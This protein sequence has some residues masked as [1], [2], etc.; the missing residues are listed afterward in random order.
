MVVEFNRGLVIGD[1]HADL[2]SLSYIL[3]RIKDGAIFLGDYA[4][5]G[6]EP[7]ESY[8]QILKKFNENQN[9]ILLR[10]NHESDAV[11]PHELPSQIKEY[12]GS[13]EVH[14]RLNKLWEKLPV[15]AI[16]KEKYWFI[17]AG[18]PTKGRED[19][20]EFKKEDFL[21]PSDEMVIEMLWNDPW[22]K[23]E[24]GENFKRGV[25]YFFGKR[26]TKAFLNEVGVEVIVRSHQPYKVLKV[27]QDG[28]VLTVGSCMKPYGLNKAAFLEIDFNEEIKSGYEVV[29]R[30]GRIFTS[31][32]V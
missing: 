21:N 26:T 27:E 5:R 15:S 8:Y 18:I 31:E 13:N 24:N 17:H 28:M 29:K 32:M 16:A 22:E 9:V 4:D 2:K 3:N 25:M 11:V 14:R 10:G 30:F 23:D 1:I 20:P 6:D 19:P 7:V 12:Y